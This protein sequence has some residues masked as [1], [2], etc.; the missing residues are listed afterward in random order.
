MTKKKI[1]KRS[2]FV[3]SAIAIVLTILVWYVVMRQI[4]VMEGDKAGEILYK[5]DNVILQVLEQNKKAKNVVILGEGYSESVN[6][7]GI[8]TYCDPL[9]FKPNTNNLFNQDTQVIYVYYPFDVE[10]QQE[11]LGVAGQEIASYINDELKDYEEENIVAIGHSKCGVC[12]A[13]MTQWLDRKITI[14]TISAPFKG[15]IVADKSLFKEKMNFFEYSIYNIMFSNHQVDKDIIAGSYFLEQANYD[16]LANQNHINIVSTCQK[17]SNNLVDKSLSYIN[18][19][20]SINGDGIVP[21]ESQLMEYE[22]TIQIF[23]EASHATSIEKGI[24]VAKQ[25]IPCLQ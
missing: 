17:E 16:G 3:V 24:E 22:N 20:Y 8:I 7:E 15:T 21:L 19:K 10:K 18:D 12:F 14:V 25:Y 6:E 23:I 4:F 11:R 9:M 5:S 2:I 1:S 13:N